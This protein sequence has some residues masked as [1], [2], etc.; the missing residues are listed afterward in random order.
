MKTNVHNLI[1]RR[2]TTYRE[3][4]I[5]GFKG[6]YNVV[7]AYYFHCFVEVVEDDGE[8][9]H[10][11]FQ[12]LNFKWGLISNF[13][14]VKEREGDTTTVEKANSRKRYPITWLKKGKYPVTIMVVG[15][16]HYGFV[17]HALETVI[18]SFL[19]ILHKMVVSCAIWLVFK[20]FKVLCWKMLYMVNKLFLRV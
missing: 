11:W 14:L 12:N 13:D 15:L 17:P 9:L 8:W 2:R 3:I 1:I 19:N 10:K 18:H 20:S 16:L 4:F 7:Y 5:N 6:L